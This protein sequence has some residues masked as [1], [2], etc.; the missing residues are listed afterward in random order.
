[1]LAKHTPVPRAGR[2]GVVKVD[3]PLGTYPFEYRGIERRD[4]GIAIVG[5]VAGL[6]SSVVLDADDLGT[7]MRRLGLP[8]GA[9]AALLALRR[10]SR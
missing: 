3:T 9:A 7:V 2:I 8:L 4:G 1:M 10:L 5:L 6:K